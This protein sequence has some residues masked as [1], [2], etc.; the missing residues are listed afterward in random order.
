MISSRRSSRSKKD[1]LEQACLFWSR[2]HPVFRDSPK[3]VTPYAADN[4]DATDDAELFLLGREIDAEDE[5]ADLN[6]PPAT[7]NVNDELPSTEPATSIQVWVAE[8]HDMPVRKRFVP[9]V[10]DSPTTSED[11]FRSG[12]DFK[13][14]RTNSKVPLI[15]SGSKKSFPTRKRVSSYEE[16]SERYEERKLVLESRSLDG[17]YRA[18]N[19]NML[20]GW[21]L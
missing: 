15:L 14:R 8:L 20:S 21:K 12:M 5:V 13:R 11:D 4:T 1:K 2:L 18:W 6:S 3:M 16:A 9:V 17:T 10:L 19:I 7:E